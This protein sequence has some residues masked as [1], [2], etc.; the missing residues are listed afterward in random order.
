MTT[1]YRC[2]APDCSRPPIDEDAKG[3]PWCEHHMPRGDVTV[4]QAKAALRSHAQ[5]LLDAM[6]PVPT[7]RCP[8]CGS[9]SVCVESVTNLWRGRPTSQ[10]VVKFCPDC[11]L[12][13]PVLKDGKWRLE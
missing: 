2:C 11:G 12:P 5:A 4:D 9:V 7:D 6:D 8:Y 3:R 1:D 10:S 13:L